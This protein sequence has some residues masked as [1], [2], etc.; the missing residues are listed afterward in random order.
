[1]TDGVF[2]LVRIDVHVS[3]DSGD[4]HDFDIIE[5]VEMVSCEEGVLLRSTRSL[6]LTKAV[7]ARNHSFLSVLQGEMANMFLNK[8]EWI[9]SIK[10][11]ALFCSV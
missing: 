5:K 2:S 7:R 3:S 9:A 4:Q 6:R 1:M 11:L 8:S 10:I